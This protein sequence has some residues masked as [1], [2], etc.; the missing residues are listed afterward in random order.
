MISD[1]KPHEKIVWSSCNVNCGSRCPL[2]LHVKDGKVVRVAPDNT[3]E[4]DFG[5]HEIRACLRGRGLR[6][7]VYSPERLLYPLIRTGRRG[8]G[9][10][11]RISWDV[12][13]DRISDKLRQVIDLWMRRPG[14]SFIATWCASTTPSAG[15]R[16]GPGSPRG[17]CRVSCHCPRA[18]G[19]LQTPMAWTRTAASTP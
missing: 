18:H 19:T 8:E 17:S 3:G 11:E 14:V 12:V 15:P 1:G 16:Y 4:D 2:R 13:L 10:F 9:K 6:K 7:W 5:R